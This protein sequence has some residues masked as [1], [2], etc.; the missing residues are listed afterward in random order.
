MARRPDITWLRTVFASRL[1]WGVAVAVF[2]ALVLAELAIF[3]PSYAGHRQ[4]LLDQVQRTG[5]A[6]LRAAH[7][8]APEDQRGFAKRLATA[9]ADSDWQ[10]AAV[11][12][13]D[14]RSLGRFGT[15]PELAGTCTGERLQTALHSDSRSRLQRYE[16][17]WPA[18]HTGLPV[19][20]AASLDVAWLP[21]KL[22]DFALRIA[23]LVALIAVA[24][25]AVLM[26]VLGRQVLRPVLGLQQQM[27]IA[28]Y[29]PEAADR[30]TMLDVPSARGELADL[31]AASQHALDQVA[32]QFADLVT[33][34]RDLEISEARFRGMFEESFDAIL[35]LESTQ[36][37]V[38]EA[39]PAAARM[40]G[41]PREALR[42]APLSALHGED[43]GRF[44]DFLDSVETNGWARSSDLTCATPAGE[45]IP[46]DVS[47][48]II[49]WTDRPMCLA[50]IRDMRAVKG[51]ERALVEAKEV[52]EQADRAKSQ[53][54]ASVS[55]ELRTPLNA[56]I[57]FSEMLSREALGPLGNAQYRTYAEDIQGA[58]QHLLEIINDILDISR[59]EA[60]RMNI[61]PAPVDLK[62]C[63]EQVFGMLNEKRA[64]SGVVL[65]A[66]IAPET[67]APVLDAR[68]LR[69]I[70]TNLI[71]N[72]IKASPAGTTVTVRAQ[73]GPG[74]QGCTIAV[75]DQGCGLSEAEVALARQPFQQ[76]GSD[77]GLAREG[78][79]G[80]GLPLAERLTQLNGGTLEIDSTPGAGTTV[81]LRFGPSPAEA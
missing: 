41:R 76:A 19:S 33:R 72:A 16:I 22:R 51:M 55:H 5:T 73:P 48:T 38:A 27:A 2:I 49:E 25:T 3:I 61:D 36:R 4:S 6:Y 68:H 23:G 11:L 18:A 69:Q 80:L 20:V 62:P 60:G 47:G 31:V 65:A 64:Q 63:T 10:G 42:G 70:L 54:L 44:Q 35:V 77:Q 32:R 24:T 26:L 14:G 21:D 34:N 74:A 1:A 40:L 29:R 56:I 58:G 39:N 78:G 15:P 75:M 66:D 59:I 7:Q 30:R 45:R 79:T 71:V 37:I 81:T 43:L 12:A 13:P 57:G 67:P 9:T 52:A 8:L 28:A 46:V 17:C 53:F 50:V